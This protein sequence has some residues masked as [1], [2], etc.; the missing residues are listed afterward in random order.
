[1]F[2]KELDSTK[3]LHEA[4]LAARQGREILLHFQGR[5]RQ[6]ENKHL[7]GQVSEADRESEKAIFA[8]LRKS[9]PEDAFLGEESAAESKMA[10]FQKAAPGQRQWVVDP[11]DGTTNY[12]Q[13]FPIYC[14]SIGC[15]VDGR[16][17]FAVIDVPALGEVYTAIRGQG[18][19]LNGKP[20]QVSKREVLGDCFVAT[21]FFTEVESRIAEQ[22]HLFN[23]L[24]RQVRAIRR[25]GAAAYDL[26]L[27][28]RGVFD[29][30]WER[31]L[32]PWDSA[33]GQLLVE[34]AGGVVLTYRGNPYNPFRNSLVA[35]NPSMAKALQK[36]IAPLVQ[37]AED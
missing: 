3:I 20:L 16:P 30:Y 19:F 32:Y 31:G 9:F 25:A 35:G 4:I 18:A 12:I 13:Q 27:V 36:K 14:V 10:T 5:L 8:H 6:V 29:I 33:A 26:A 7:A 1:M 15:L 2:N 11:L 17:E 24:V 37:L 23:N 21:G 34:E 28:A 22:L